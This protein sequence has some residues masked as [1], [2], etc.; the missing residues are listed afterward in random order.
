MIMERFQRV[1]ALLLVALFYCNIP[2]LH[3]QS[4]DRLWKQ[5][6]EAQKKSLPQTVIKLTDEIFNKAE[7]EQNAPQMLKAYTCRASWRESLT[8]D[9]LYTHLEQLKRW[10]GE[11]RNPVTRAVLNT[12]VANSFADY[13]ARHRW[14][15]QK[16]TALSPDNKS[17]SGDIREWSL[18]LFVNQVLKYTDEALRDSAV[19][20]KTSS[21]KYLPFV[22]QGDASNYYRHD[23]YHLLTTLNLDA[24]VRVT[25]L[26][27]DTVIGG[28]ID[29]LYQSM[30]STYRRMP[31]H[32]DAVVLSTL[33][34]LEWVNGQHQAMYRTNQTETTEEGDHKSYLKALNQ[35]ITE[36]GKRD[37]CAEVYLVKAR[38]YQQSGQLPKALAICDDAI[39]LYASYPRI[40]AL[41]ELRESIICPRLI[42]NTSPVAYPGDS[43]KLN[44]H[45][46]NLNGFAVNLFYLKT[47]PSVRLRQDRVDSL[48]RKS[49]VKV[50]TQ[51]FDLKRSDRYV[52]NDT[53]FQLVMPAT[54]GHY[55]LQIVPADKRAKGEQQIISLTRF[56][57]L[58][59]KL[60]NG[61]SEVA[62]LDSRTGAPVPDA[63]ITFYSKEGNALSHLNTDSN[64]KVQTAWNLAFRTLIAT[65]GADQ[66]MIPE[67][68]Y[69]NG[70]Q[71]WNSGKK[72]E[73]YIKL[74]TDRS[75]YRP[76]QTI[77]IKGIAYEQQQDTATALSG[78][79]YQVAL[80]DVNY[81]EI[82]HKEVRT[83]TFGSFATEFTLPA[84]CLSGTYTLEVPGMNDGNLTVQVEEYKRPTFDIVFD[85]TKKAYQIGDS[86]EIG[87]KVST[88]SGV[89]MEGL[90]L[91]YTLSSRQRSFW[92]I[93][94]PASSP[95]ESGRVKIGRNGLF[96]I[97][98]CLR[99][100]MDNAYD[101]YVYQVEATVT[102]GSGETQTGST[103]LVAGNRSVILS[104]DADER[105]CKDDTIRMTFFA[106]NLNQ[107]PV[108]LTG[109]YELQRTVAGKEEVVLRSTFNSNQE[110]VLPDWRTLP[111]GVYQLLLSAKD[112]E[113]RAVDFKQKIVLFS[114]QENRP[115][116][117]S[118]F[119][120]Y[121]R[122]LQFDALHPAEFAIG[123]S[124]RD[125]YV[126]LDVFSGNHRLRSNVVLLSDSVVR[127][128]EPYLPE[129]GD[130]VVMLFTFVKDGTVYSKRVELRKR[131]PE[132]ALKMKWETFRDK[133][134]PG[135]KE[136]WK[137]VITTPQGTP[138]NAELLAMMYDASLDKLY[139]NRQSFR[140]NYPLYLPVFSWMSGYIR[141]NYYYY[142]FITKDWK[143]P[144][145]L[146][147]HL[148]SPIIGNQSNEIFYA[149]SKEA[150]VAG[151]AGG[152][153]IRGKSAMTRKTVA[154]GVEE[155]SALLNEVVRVADQSDS[156]A[157]ASS[158]GELLRTN[159]NETA[160][161]YPQ[162]RTN[163]KGE[164][165][166]SFVMPESLTRWNFRAYAHTQGMLTGRLDASVVTAKEFMLT[167]NLPRFV[168]TGDRTSVA[169]TVANLTGKSQ[170]GIVKLV[171]FDPMTEQVIQTQQV[172]FNAEAGQT[173]PVSFRFVVTDKFSLLGIR[174]V[175]DGGLFS[176]GEQ[177]L[178]PVLSD[179][180]YL[181]ETL[182]LP[183]RG[184]ETRMFAL[185]S[186]FNHQ[187]PTAIH[188]RLTVEFTGNPSWYAVQ[189]LPALSQPTNDN[190]VSWATAYYANALSAY[191]LN[192]NPR[193]KSV[194]DSWQLKPEYK[195]TLQS[196]LLKNRDLKNILLEET[197]WLLEATT[198]TEQRE[199]LV[200]FF[201]PNNL[202]N[203][204]ITALTKLREL[205]NPDGAWSWYKGMAGSR[206]MTGYITGLLVRLASLTGG[207]IPV[208]VLPM[209]QQALKYLHQAA[210]NE[211]REL[212]K[213]EKKGL[214]SSQLSDDAMTYLYLIA[215][216]GEKVPA[217]NE[218]AYRYFLSKVHTNLE[219]GSIACKAESAIILQKAGSMAEAHDFIASI[220]EHLVRTDERGAY[221][222]FNET[223][224]RWSRSGVV[225][226][227]KAMEALNAMGG[228][229]K[230]VEEMKIWLLKQKQ[231]TAWNTP[232]ATAD[233]V[234]ALLCRGN[235]LLSDGGRARIKI[236]KTTL[237]AGA[238]S[239]QTDRSLTNAVPGLSYFKQVYTGGSPE[240]GAKTISI[241]K[242][243]GGIGWGAVYAQYQEKIAAVKQQ[244]REL[245]V[246]K[247]LY[248]ERTLSDGSKQLQAVDSTVK[249]SVGDKVIS[250]L[251]IRLDRA[252]DF[253]Q[254][255]D[256]RGACFE[257][258]NSLSGYRWDGRM[259]YYME[260]EDAATNFFFDHLS[261]GVYV[262][263][264]AYRI[265][266]AGEY[267]GGLA[268]VQS[269]YAAE[270]AAH[271]AS[272]KVVITDS[273]MSKGSLQK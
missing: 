43:L 183:I 160:F 141:Q 85:A 236:G 96:T 175:A 137:L 264:D 2:V 253:V 189:S 129:Y 150:G 265:A 163:E 33:D 94:T 229:P 241:E 99:G 204:T 158:D 81:Q 271:S 148:Y 107:E 257:P 18:N 134:Y 169:A 247:K 27:Q 79:N 154:S 121:A 216:S 188:R 83:N 149:V 52:A 49:G 111:S 41:K 7:L 206:S 151:Y 232:I 162:L 199:R 262:L 249:L 180:Q 255:K 109:N 55:V 112:Q 230:L 252:M 46:Q 126:L 200:Q 224:Y 133:L 244:G 104:V 178:L 35:L 185:D 208:D 223:P 38:Y 59:M 30:I 270:Y 61:K 231:V 56:K 17:L 98:I 203:G 102:N 58:T 130:G 120:F 73:T 237:E 250:R 220:E 176:D 47:S 181:T 34:Y 261:K 210:L 72:A 1:F 45:H 82:A 5:V 143:I 192:S 131:L 11:E 140:L 256:E 260:V 123:T 117:T 156:D 136:E 62:A 50:R 184:N 128:S 14:E 197:P 97:P 108:A 214:K 51:L 118:D 205:Q 119:W 15:L 221:F 88:F 101:S 173:V 167:P 78:K 23:M 222:A 159:F 153:L 103:K 20:L 170:K 76:G 198:E 269:A 166:F 144:A 147:D 124:H 95:L 218:T 24:L 135:R 233:A 196:Q 21:G 127:F 272:A 228:E 37:I 53:V 70:A 44:V 19:L 246:E 115:A 74:L 202:T 22:I 142:T 139:P 3:A 201:N 39:R 36:Y 193:I 194:F 26:N 258:E 235:D 28:R 67:R 125:A 211:Y 68:I 89:P 65:K 75:I 122:N 12:L 152:A 254:L 165:V 145:L 174:M 248:V 212:R 191:I 87:G 251:T 60:P 155:E 48:L 239:A 105:I 114:Y 138:A 31:G 240:V 29:T 245:S 219:Q 110:T 132:K 195:Q 63:T 179:K 263:E 266:R 10:A 86:V 9:S 242:Q 268:T 190:A 172:P 64:G 207:Q 42:I 186:L 25:Q 6:E 213:A 227:V 243:D 66:F 93:Y 116:E 4:Y 84:A 177:H 215:V 54:P 91:H 77:Y 57:V 90:E 161:F 168:R 225:A 40:T 164:V 100:A 80:R 238:S 8:P 209:E 273:G 32:E 182:A 106:R 217:A 146:Y 71:G 267:E 157:G 226:Q 16:H 259:G 92:K 69:A 13:A 171:L 113:G 234:Y 187:S